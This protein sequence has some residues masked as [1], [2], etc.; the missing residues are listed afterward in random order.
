M[1]AS[2]AW[3]DRHDAAKHTRYVVQRAGG[4]RGDNYLGLGLG[5][6]VETCI[7]FDPWPFL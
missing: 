5:G 2:D 7:G 6:L 1:I 4:T 3:Q